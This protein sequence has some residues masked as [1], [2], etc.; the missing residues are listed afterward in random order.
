MFVIL[1]H[2]EEIFVNFFIDDACCL[3]WPDIFTTLLEIV[4]YVF[5][6]VLDLVSRVLAML[7]H[8]VICVYRFALYVSLWSWC[9]LI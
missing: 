8:V 5:I 7:L 3:M 2:M 6:I 9:F 1:H 4:T